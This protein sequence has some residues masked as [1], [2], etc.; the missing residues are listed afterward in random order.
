MLHQPEHP[1]SDALAWCDIG[2]TVVSLMQPDVPRKGPEDIQALL[3]SLRHVST[4]D[5]DRACS[6]LLGHSPT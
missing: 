4:D 6:I 2:M 5:H 3:C 1:D